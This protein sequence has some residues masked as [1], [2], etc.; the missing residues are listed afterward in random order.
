M[1]YRYT[2]TRRL[3]TALVAT[4]VIGLAGLSVGFTQDPADPAGS[5]RDQIGPND[6][7]VTGIV[8]A[9]HEDTFE[10]QSHGTLYF[11]EKPSDAAQRAHVRTGTEVQVFFD[12]SGYQRDGNSYY[13][14]SVIARTGESTDS[15]T[16]TDLQTASTPGVDGDPVA[17][18]PQ[19]RTSTQADQA[20]V[21]TDA[22]SSVVT[23]DSQQ[24]PTRLAQNENPNRYDE[25]TLPQT[26]GV[27][28]LVGLTGF[29]GLLGAVAL[30]VFRS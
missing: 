22:Q 16:A 7:Q 10:L 18:E 1:R 20:L 3:A 12:P 4:L 25:Q 17:A 27:L 11:F 21:S 6:E 26:A 9:V 28:P 8:G 15:Q 5:W 30:R 19:S 23:D 13:R 14:P 29:L 2:S 24:D